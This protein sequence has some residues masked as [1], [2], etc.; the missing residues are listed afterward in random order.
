MIRAAYRDEVEH[1]AS[2]L[3]IAVDSET[4]GVLYEDERG[5][6]AMVIYDSWTHSA[7]QVH[8]YSNGPDRLLR[9]E[10]LREVFWYP[11]V[12]CGKMLVYSVTPAD[13]EESL[14]VSK[15]LG[16]VEVFRQKDGWDKGVDMV[17]KEMR[18]E[19]CRWIE[20]LH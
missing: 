19:N 13:S 2:L 17:I 3:P 4:R 11:F 14:A 10:F 18:R 6:G 16:F 8:V 1:I 7:V 12:Q 5:L 15:A 20:E 9:R